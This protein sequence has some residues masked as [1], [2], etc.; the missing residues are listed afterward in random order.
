MSKIEVNTVDVQCGSTLT[1]GS[2]GKTVQ[3]ATGAS[4]T[5]FGS[6]GGISWQTS[7]KTTDFTAVSNE[8]YFVN[9]S[10]GSNITVTLPSSPSAGN[11]VA[12]KDY[13]RTFG[14]NK[15]IVA[16]NGSNMDGNAEDTDLSTDG[17]SVTLVFMDSTKGWSFINEDDTTQAGAAFITATGGTTSTCGNFKV[18]TFTS[19]GTFCVSCGGNSGGSNTVDYFVVAGGGG[20]SGDIGGGGGAGGF[21]LSNSTCMP[22]TQTSPLA[23]PTA[24]PVSVQGYPITVGAGGAGSPTG[25]AP[26]TASSPGSNS[27][28]ST[29]ISAGGGGSSASAFCCA[30]GP[31]SG[32]GLP[33][34]SGG[35]AKRA[36]G[37]TGGT[38]NTPSVSPPQGNNGGSS[39][40]T[41]PGPAFSAGGG[42]AGAAG[43][44]GQGASP[45]PAAGGGGVGSFVVSAG[46][47]GCNGT[48]GPV[49][50]ARYF[51]GGGSGGGSSAAGDRPTSGTVGGGGGSGS[52]DSGPNGDPGDANTGGGGSAGGNDSSGGTGGSGIVIIRYKFQ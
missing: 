1:L 26:T 46:F 50:G 21:R 39:V 17:I 11:V 37:H 52:G 8:G 38:G 40:G 35:G 48:T 16:R 3:L 45:G 15:V 33:G 23:T 10:G 9:T 12:I 42:G 32:N 2:S 14:T 25:N 24:L 47:A 43:G 6:T 44:C 34:G 30:T 20:A 4:Q 5:G 29:I 28:F 27:V 36:R 18:H 22:G 51:S 7:I 31:D 41:A 49:S 13:A 19:P